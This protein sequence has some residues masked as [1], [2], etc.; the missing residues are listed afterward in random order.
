MYRSSLLALFFCAI[1]IVSAS[2]TA[3]AAGGE[4]P[5]PLKEW[6]FLTYLN[7]NNDLDRFG[8]TNMNQMEEI[9]STADINV[10]VQWASLARNETLRILVQKDSDSRK[11]TSPVVQNLGGVDMGD[12]RSL[13]DF[14]EWGVRTYPA[15]KYF[16]NVWNH[17]SGWHLKKV[18]NIGSPRISP[19]DISHDERTGNK[20]TTEELGRAMNEASRNIGRKIDL[21]ASDACLMGMAEIASEMVDSVRFFGGSEETEP[22]SGW[23]YAE[24]LAEWAAKPKADGG[25]V[26]A[27]LT[28]TYVQSYSGGSNGNENVTFSIFDLEQLPSLEQSMQSLAARLGTLG[29]ADRKT[30][31]RASEKALNFTLADYVDLAD[32]LKYLGTSG[33][34]SMDPASINS[35][36]AALS[37]VVIANQATGRYKPAGGLSFWFPATISRYN[38][39]EKR[40]RDLRFNAETNWGDALE[41]LLSP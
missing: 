4:N 18:G 6:T 26:G 37:R 34:K 21:Y 35:V 20:I 27:M 28:R 8:T 41:L 23:P 30:V 22:G 1:S 38:S 24:F 15:K 40:Y 36:R 25:E 2:Q 10:V 11:V 39:Y 5:P 29:S 31:I 9:G 33:I 14:I 17:G 7:G 3:T 12:W 13:V 32:F 16:I 19:S